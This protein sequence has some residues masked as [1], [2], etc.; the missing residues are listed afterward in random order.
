MVL[1]LHVYFGAVEKGHFTI[2]YYCMCIVIK[3]VLYAN[4]VYVLLLIIE[5]LK[6]S[7]IT[8]NIRK[9]QRL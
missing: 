5:Y 1:L 7:C 4:L 3:D 6:Q 2:T 8:I 9:L